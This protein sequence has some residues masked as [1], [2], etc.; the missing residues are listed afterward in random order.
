MR[1]LKQL[2]LFASQPTT[3]EEIA[4]HTPLKA[5]IALFQQFLVKEGKSDHTVKAFTSDLQLVAERL[6]EDTP[7][8]EFT[9]SM[10]NDFMHWLEYGRDVPCSRKSYARRV[11]TVKVYFKWL[12]AIGA[13]PHDPAK[14]VL[15]RSGP[16]PLADILTMPQMRAAIE[17]SQRMR[18]GQ[19]QDYR[20]EMLL[21]LLLDT[22]I[23]KSEAMLLTP[24]DIDRLNPHQT[25]LIVRHKSRNVYRERR[26]EIDPD[27]VKLLD[28]YL[29]QYTPKDTIF[30][31]TSRNLEYILTD[32]GKGAGIEPKLSFE[33]LRWTCAVRDFRQGMDEQLIRE[34]LG[35]SKISWHETG[36]K[37]KRLAALAE[38]QEKGIRRLARAGV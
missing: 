19:A 30:N 17:F 21:R 27:W 20:P 6:G 13:I 7:V 29:D 25:L 26:I 33:M 35:L 2:S 28:L 16:A 14:A 32:I 22:G 15:Q 1:D 9:T 31:C 18:K 4:R 8:G 11:T 34:K 23:K 37:I 36:T 12:Y 5:T 38:D 10:L 3:P 24:R